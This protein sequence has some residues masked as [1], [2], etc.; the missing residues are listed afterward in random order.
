MQN[1]KRIATLVLGGL[2]T[3]AMTGGALKAADQDDHDEDE[4]KIALPAEQIIASVRTAIASKPG[5]IL[6]VEGESEKGQ[7]LCE[8]E[9]VAD[10]GKTY[11]VAVDV[12][13]NKAISVELDD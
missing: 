4:T 11:E 3:L 6:A 7:T 9:I 10:D 5:R 13:T 1:K 12:A 8:V 2:V